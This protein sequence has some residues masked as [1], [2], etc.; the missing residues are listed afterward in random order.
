MQ[1]LIDHVAFEL[2]LVDR[3]DLAL[4]RLGVRRVPGRAAAD[5][6]NEIGILEMLVGGDPEIERVVGRE[7]GK[8]GDAAP[9]RRNRQKIGKLD[10]R[11][12][13]RRIAAGL[14]GD[15]D[16]IFCCEQKACDLCHLVGM[17]LEARCE[18][19]V[20]IVLRRRPIMKHVLERDVE[21]HRALGR[22]L[23]HLAGAD[24]LLVEREGAGDRPRLLGDVLDEALDA[25]DAQAAVPLLLDRQR[26][27]LAQRIGL[28]RHHDHRDFR[29]QRAVHA[30]RALQEA[31]AGMDQHGLRPAGHQRVAGRHVDGEGLV[32]AVDIGRAGAVAGL[33][34]HQRFPDRRPFR[35]RRR[36]NVVDLELAERF[37]DR[38]PAV[39]V[40]FHCFVLMPRTG[41]HRTRKLRSR[42]QCQGA[43]AMP[44]LQG[45]PSSIRGQIL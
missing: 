23:R 20:A 7:I 28:A 37:Q 9:H 42:Q 45:V 29:L 39:H 35:S 36:Q 13:C 40:V 33:L 44:C 4:G 5:E 38:F 15:D 30:H 26:R 11:L 1:L 19:H 3:D 27:I 12:E 10:Q 17:G 24:H 8:I 18:R 2:V 25:A 22:A 31:D 21:I 6:Q 16:W 34:P 14:L 41:R 32:P 43:R